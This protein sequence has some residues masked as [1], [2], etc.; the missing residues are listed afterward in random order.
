MRTEVR[1]SRPRSHETTK[2]QI[3]RKLIAAGEARTALL[4]RAYPTSVQEPVDGD[5]RA[6]PPPGVVHRADG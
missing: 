3:G 4:R 6:P 5:H 2:R 1:A